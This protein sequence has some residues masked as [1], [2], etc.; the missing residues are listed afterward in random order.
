[1]YEQQ[2]FALA[3]ADYE[4]QRDIDCENAMF[5]DDEDDSEEV[6]LLDWNSDPIDIDKDYYEVYEYGGTK[7]PD[8]VVDDI[9]EI[10][11][12]L[13]NHGFDNK[14]WFIQHYGRYGID[15]TV[16]RLQR[17]DSMNEYEFF[18]E[19]VDCKFMEAKK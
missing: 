11:L 1:M 8:L 14:V 19:F 16:S 6:L 17:Y 10:S 9:Q 5:S 18:Q 4:R 3:E 2:D 13:H 7:L 15:E 12:W